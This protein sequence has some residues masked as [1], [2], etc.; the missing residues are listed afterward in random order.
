MKIPKL[1]GGWRRSATWE[2]SPHNPVFFLTTSLSISS[3]YTQL[4]HITAFDEASQ[5]LKTTLEL[6]WEN[7]PFPEKLEKFTHKPLDETIRMKM[8]QDNKDC[9]KPSPVLFKMLRE[10]V[11][12]AVSERED[13]VM[14]VTTLMTGCAE[15][16]WD[17]FVCNWAWLSST[18]LYRT[19][20]GCT[21]LYWAGLGCTEL[22]L[23]E[24]GCTRLHQAILSCTE[25]Y[26]V[27]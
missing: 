15:L 6:T 1:G 4:M 24:L 27:Y 17:V 7:H 16:Y 10:Q 14:G 25:M 13:G 21:G 20:R 12:Y 2:F 8:F 5:L 22:Y 19:V 23:G 9:P 11:N 3:R 26:W 18:G